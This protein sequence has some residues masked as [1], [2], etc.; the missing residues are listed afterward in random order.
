[1]NDK[2]DFLLPDESDIDDILKQVKS[3]HTPSAEP[4]PTPKKLP[5]NE[6]PGPVSA[7]SEESGHIIQEEE[8]FPEQAVVFSP[9]EDFNPSDFVFDAED[10]PTSEPAE[11]DMMKKSVC[12]L[13]GMNL[14][15]NQGTR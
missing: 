2:M 14:K 3:F 8:D 11:E 12:E 6:D 10:E 5:K 13:P 9:E 1:M 7:F 4:P 15:A